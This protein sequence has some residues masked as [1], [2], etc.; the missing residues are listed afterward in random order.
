VRFPDADLA[1]IASAS[2]C[3]AA[4][5]RNPGDLLVVEQWL[6]AGDEGPLVLDAKVNPNICA[7]WL[8]EAFRAG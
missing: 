7:E 2:G 5:V 4:T 8:E 3:S 1:A 6:E